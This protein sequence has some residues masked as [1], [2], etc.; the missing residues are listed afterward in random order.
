LDIGE[1]KNLIKNSTS[2]LVIDS[3]EPS[4]VILD[5]NVYKNFMSG[6]N[7]NEHEIKI[8]QELRNSLA[9]PS[10]DFANSEQEEATILE[11]LNKEILSL[12][13]QIEQAEIEEKKLTNPHFEDI[14]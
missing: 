10:K 5:Y 14:D 13:N 1:L 12:K 3:G 6:K 4:F 11:K 2:V 7:I 9:S 8:K